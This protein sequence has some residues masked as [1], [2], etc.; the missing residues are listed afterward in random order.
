MA[1]RA[2]V[3]AGD[4]LQVGAPAE[5][6]PE[7]IE[8]MLRDVVQGRDDVAFA[9]LP[10]IAFPGAAAERVLVVYL[11]GGRDIE[12]ALASLSTQVSAGFAA[13]ACTHPDLIPAPIAVMPIDLD[14]PLDALAQAVVFTRTDLYVADVTA[15]QDALRGPQPFILR[16]LRRLGIL[17]R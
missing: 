4:E 6:L 9:C 14:R 2:Q 7:P 17:Q 13:V 12:A 5:P 11:R 10:V 15:W 3:Q 1:G 16:W 8:L